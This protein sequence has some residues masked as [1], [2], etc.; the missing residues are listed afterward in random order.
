MSTFT[1]KRTLN[2]DESKKAPE[3]FQALI[4]FRFYKQKYN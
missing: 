1:T 3:I 2:F 4:I